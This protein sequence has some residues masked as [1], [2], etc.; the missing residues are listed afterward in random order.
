ML[1][2]EAFRS[3]SLPYIF[4]Q[5]G[6]LGVNFNGIGVGV[7]TGP[8]LALDIISKL[9][10]AVTLVY[11]VRIICNAQIYFDISHVCYLCNMLVS[12]IKSFLFFTAG[13]Y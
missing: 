1:P 2:V 6:L 10:N 8:G 3:L 11:L 4:T 7:E 13:R 12:L 5:K 9:I